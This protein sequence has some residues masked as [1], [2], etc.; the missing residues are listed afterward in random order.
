MIMAYLVIVRHGQSEYNRQNKFTGQLDIPLSKFGEKEAIVAGRKM[1]RENL[2]FHNF[3]TSGLI[4]AYSTIEIILNELGLPKTQTLI[5]RTDAFNERNYGELEGMNKTKAAQKY[6][7]E[8]IHKWR[9]GFSSKPPGGESL[10]D[11]YK[12][13]LAYYQKNVEPLLK[14]GKNILMVA[15]GNSLRALMMYLEKIGKRKIENIEIPT[16]IPRMY[17]LTKR[18]RVE[19]VKYL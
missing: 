16:G 13:V 11:T 8:Q 3:F 5:I 7:E 6:S 14:K 15:H 18:L 4:R 2:R 12:R 10:E 1:L 9:R 17:Q 19:T